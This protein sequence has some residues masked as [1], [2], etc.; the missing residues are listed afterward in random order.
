[1]GDR[2]PAGSHYFL[3]D[4]RRT[5]CPT[6]WGI[7]NALAPGV[8][9]DILAAISRQT[10]WRIQPALSQEVGWSVLSPF[11]T[12]DLSHC[13]PWK[14]SFEAETVQY[15]FHAKAAPMTFT[16]ESK[17]FLFQAKPGSGRTL[18]STEMSWGVNI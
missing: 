13:T 2:E 5:L 8:S 14:M 17:P 3:R 16:A 9:W 1:M 7:M 11:I 6:N 10:D 4:C 12:Q 15:V 18:L